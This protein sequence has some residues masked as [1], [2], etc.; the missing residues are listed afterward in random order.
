MRGTQIAKRAG[1]GRSFI[2]NLLPL[3]LACAAAAACVDS[4]TETAAPSSL[5]D[6]NFLATSFD[7]LS[8]SAAAQGDLERGEDFHWAALAVRLGV[9]PSR[10]DIDNNGTTESFDAFVHVVAWANPFAA[11]A[12]RP[13][14]NRSFIA[15]RKGSEKLQVLVVGSAIDIAEVGESATIRLGPAL[16]TSAT[17]PITFGSATYYERG[18]TPSTWIGVGGTARIA[19]TGTAGEACVL[20]RNAPDGVGCL[21]ARFTV[22]LDLKLARA[23]NDA[24]VKEANAAT[25][26]MTMAPQPVAGA[27]LVFNCASPTSDK[28][29]G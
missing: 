2:S 24:R 15:W 16:G 5:A 21:V 25:R 26:T 18:A 19:A 23:R 12:T 6:E 4:P 29:C 8:Q 17:A 27:R 10:V 14:A 20:P 3:A 9:S 22:G 28:G 13:L 7:S 1:P 11:S